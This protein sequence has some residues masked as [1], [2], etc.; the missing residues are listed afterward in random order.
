MAASLQ[1]F[2]QSF[3]AALVAGAV[4]PYV[5]GSGLKLAITSAVLLASGAVCAF[6]YS[7]LPRVAGAT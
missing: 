2:Q 4:S 6:I 1:G 5:A 7:R 3:F